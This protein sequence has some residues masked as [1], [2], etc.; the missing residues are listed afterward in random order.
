MSRAPTAPPRDL[1]TGRWGRGAAARAGTADGPDRQPGDR[2][3]LAGTGG[4]V[5]A[6]RGVERVLVHVLAYRPAL[7]RPAARGKQARPGMARPI[8][9]ADGPARPRWWHRRRMVRACPASRPGLAGPW[10]VLPARGRSAG[11]VGPVLLC[12]AHASPPRSEEH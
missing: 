8:R 6:G 12:A 5:R 4:S 9:A 1:G 3:A 10:P 7:P 2:R 11:V